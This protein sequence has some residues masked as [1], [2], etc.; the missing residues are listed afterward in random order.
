MAPWKV[1]LMFG[2]KRET[3]TIQSELAELRESSARADSASTETVEARGRVEWLASYISDRRSRN[4][5]GED[6]EIS[7]TLRRA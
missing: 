4:G 5:L 7:K 2:R 6:Y 3:A 1:T